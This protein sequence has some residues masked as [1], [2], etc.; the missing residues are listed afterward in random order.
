VLKR[1][2][3]S[4]MQLRGEDLATVLQRAYDSFAEE[5]SEKPHSRQT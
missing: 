2:G 5:S 4:G 3:P 1:L